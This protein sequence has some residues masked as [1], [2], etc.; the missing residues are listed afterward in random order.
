[1]MFVGKLLRS[2]FLFL[3][4]ATSGKMHSAKLDSLLNVLPQSKG[5][6]RLKIL[7]ELSA[8]YVR[9]DPQKFLM[10]NK[11]A[12]SLC[13]DS[14]SYFKVDAYSTFAHYLGLKGKT[15]QAKSTIFKLISECEK[16]K[17]RELLADAFIKLALIYKRESIYDSAVH[18]SI[19]SEKLYRQ[20]NNLSGLANS[21][22]NGAGIYVDMQEFDKA[23]EKYFAALKISR[24]N[25]FLRTTITSLIGIGIFYGSQ[26]M[27]DSAVHYLER[28]AMEAQAIRDYDL[29]STA[30]S[31]LGTASMMT[32]KTK[33]A[34]GYY[35]KNFELKKNSDSK[36][37]MAT[38]LCDLATAYSAVGKSDSALYCLNYADRISDS[39]NS[40]STKSFVYESFISFYK[41]KGDYKRVTEYYE[42]K[43]KS[44]RKMFSEQKQ[45][46]LLEL[47]T[48]YE[49]DKQTAEIKLRDEQL[50]NKEV[51]LKQ[52][53]TVNLSIAAGLI[54]VLLLA[55]II[56]RSLQQTRRANRII[57]EQKS[58][59]ENQKLLIEEKQKE[60]VDSINYGRRIQ[61]ALMASQRLLDEQL[62]DYFILFLPKDIVSGDFYWA[63][64][65][66]EGRLIFVTADSTGHGVPGAMMSMLNVACL[67]EAVNERGLNNPAAILDYCREKIIR[68]LSEDGSKDGGSDGMDASVMVLEDRNIKISSANGPVFVAR[69]GM[70]I[71]AETN[72]MPVGRHALQDTPFSETQIALEAGD[73]IYTLTDGFAD[74]FGGS[75]GKKFM[76]KE[77]K[78]L[79]VQISALPLHEQ[80]EKLETTFSAWRG[81]LEQVDDVTVIGIKI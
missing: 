18:Y 29:L 48:L 8:H 16:E 80:K 59:V 6:E 12:M 38:T 2:V 7:N 23:G 41:N 43:S 13:G 10:Y 5:V 1:M 9:L 32:G 45:K 53:K 33:A 60:I 28:S 61:K 35:L 15:A 19:E 58:Q 25:D 76:K 63:S 42:K 54:L 51:K 62:N 44:D 3:V 30:Y 74:Q 72:K 49:L 81:Q 20:A 79:L 56:F 40:P 78:K 34:L 27:M 21:L 75:N 68:S 67:N 66:K 37:D 77:L 50:L 39:I 71:E 70:L 24:E 57:S 73:I 31:N 52:Q 69:K 64:K 55:F 4:L 11:E 14:V 26:G 65:T 22:S 46:S 47:E 36:V 17:R